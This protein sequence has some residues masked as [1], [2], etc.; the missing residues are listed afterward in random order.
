MTGSS[1]P[2]C[3]RGSDPWLSS[4]SACGWLSR[5]CERTTTAVRDS[6]SSA[7]DA[8][9]TAARGYFEAASSETSRT[10]W[11]GAHAWTTQARHR[12]S[13]AQKSWTP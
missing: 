2:T 5:R 7:N 4:R 9:S 1:M 6:E 10:Q 13:G 3:V 8:A 11:R 12:T